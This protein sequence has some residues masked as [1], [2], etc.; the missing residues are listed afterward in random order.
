MNIPEEPGQ[1][2]QPFRDNMQ[3]ISSNEIPPEFRD[4]VNEAFHLLGSDGPPQHVRM[5]TSDAS[6]TVN[7][8]IVY[9]TT[10]QNARPAQDYWV[11]W[12]YSDEEWRQFDRVDWGRTLR[13]FLLF[14]TIGALISAAFFTGLGLLL[15]QAF[16]STDGSGSAVLPVFILMAALFMSDFVVLSLLLSSPLRMAWKR[17]TA[18]QTGPHRVTIGSMNMIG[19]QSL[20]EAGLYIPLQEA[21]IHLTSVRLLS[22]PP[23]LV[24]HQKNFQRRNIHRDTIPILVPSGHEH[25]AEQLVQ[26]LHAETIAFYNKPRIPAEPR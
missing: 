25:E 23:L 13:R 17:H 15:L 6:Y 1:S 7:D 10:T 16:S 5:Y 24:L 20:W 8:P 9:T 19:D 2:A 12:E 11:R 4:M 14:I 26:R 18:R 21:F 3:E 22:Q